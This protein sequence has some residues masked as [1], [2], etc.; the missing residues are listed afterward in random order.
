MT[1]DITRAW[2]AELGHLEAE[3]QQSFG[4]RP[5]EDIRKSLQRK[6]RMLELQRKICES[7]KEEFAEPIVLDL[8]FGMEWYAVLGWSAATL[9][10]NLYKPVDG[11]AC[12]AIT[13]KHIFGVRMETLNDEIFEA[14]PLYR[15]GLDLA[16]VFKIKYSTWKHVVQKCHSYHECYDEN[17]WQDVN[18]FLFRDKEGD[19]HC[20]AVEFKVNFVDIDLTQLRSRM[21]FWK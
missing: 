14:H 10:V 20:L 8:P 17:L 12:A 2:E 5:S 1:T 4:S 15:K 16:G 18:H 6:Q 19:F 11:H 13:F 7:R 3:E 9:L 21:T